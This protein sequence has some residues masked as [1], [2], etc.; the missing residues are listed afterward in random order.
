MFS[1][2]LPILYLITLA[3]EIIIKIHSHVYQFELNKTIAVTPIGD[4]RR[5]LSEETSSNITS[6][7]LTGEKIKAEI[8]HLLD[9]F[10]SIQ[11][12]P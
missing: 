8:S 3:L 2:E 9:L 10:H 6:Q 5:A 7:R 11:R 12:D 1:K 4:G